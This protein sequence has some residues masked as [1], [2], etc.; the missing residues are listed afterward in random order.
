VENFIR[1]ISFVSNILGSPPPLKE[2][3]E[4]MRQKSFFDFSSLN[5]SVDPFRYKKSIAFC[6]NSIAKKLPQS[7]LETVHF[8]DSSNPSAT[9][10]KTDF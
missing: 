7:P 5:S 8:S 9:E 6:Q 10:N 1:T 4:N 3:L 2:S